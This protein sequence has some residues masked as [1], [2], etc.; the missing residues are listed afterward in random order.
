MNNG[1]KC[2]LSKETL[3][4]NITYRFKDCITEEDYNLLYDRIGHQLKFEVLA[5]MYNCSLSTIKRKYV[6]A[7]NKAKEYVGE[8]NDKKGTK[9]VNKK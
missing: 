2:Q 9:K 4:Y 5:E 3:I 1:Y 6:L 8:E 7:L